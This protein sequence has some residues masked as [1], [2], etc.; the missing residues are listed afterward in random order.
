MIRQPHRLGR[1]AEKLAENYL[2]NRGLSL[3]ERNFSCRF[4]EIDLIMEENDEI[5]FIEVRFRQYDSF[6]SAKESITKTKQRKIIKTAELYLQE[7]NAL[8]IKPM[9]FDVLVLS[10]QLQASHVEWIKNA[11]LMS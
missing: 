1:L 10:S 7:R 11:F 3:I 9:R 8:N 6:G 4:G 2:K 5:V